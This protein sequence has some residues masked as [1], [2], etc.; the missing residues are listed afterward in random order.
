MEKKRSEKKKKR[1]NLP[2]KAAYIPSHPS[3]FPCPTAVKHIH[4]LFAM[5]HIKQFSRKNKEDVFSS[6]SQAL[7]P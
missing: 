1:P 3:P 4:S 7:S 5:I 2:A 6:F